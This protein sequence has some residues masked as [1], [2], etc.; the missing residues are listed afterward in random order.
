MFLIFTEDIY[1]EGRRCVNFSKYDRLNV[2]D[3][4]S[5]TIS[6]DKDFKQGVVETGLSAYAVVAERT[7]VSDG[8]V[9]YDIL[10]LATTE[11]MAFE[12]HNHLMQSIR[13][14]ITAAEGR[15][16]FCTV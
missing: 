13:D 8:G 1:R 10:A 16:T 9:E 12:K 6:D 14:A 11:A 3:I 5:I 7:V 2:R 15:D 4:S